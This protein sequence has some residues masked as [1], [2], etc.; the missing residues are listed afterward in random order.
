[1]AGGR[2]RTPE[3]CRSVPPDMTASIIRLRPIRLMDLLETARLTGN[4]DHAAPIRHRDPDIINLPAFQIAAY[5]VSHYGVL[6]P[7]Q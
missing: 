4:Q 7:F 1:M 6:A 3:S 2:G 5:K